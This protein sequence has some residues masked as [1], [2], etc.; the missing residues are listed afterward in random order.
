MHQ[1]PALGPKPFSP[2]NPATLQP[3]PRALA[4]GSKPSTSEF[5]VEVHEFGGKG[6]G[7]L[8]HLLCLGVFAALRIDLGMRTKRG[9]SA[10]GRAIFYMWQ[11]GWSSRGCG[12]FEAPQASQGGAHVM[13]GRDAGHAL[14]T[15]AV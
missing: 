7:L 14:V 3:T 13:C 6:Q 9:R 2:C 4:H 5:F 8:K 11:R 15:R 1:P 12:I 10:T